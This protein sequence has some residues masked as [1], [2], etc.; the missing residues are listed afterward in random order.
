MLFFL[1]AYGIGWLLWLP[2]L[3][4]RKGLGLISVDLDFT[5]AIPG[6]FSPL[7][8]AL[9]V[10][11]IIMGNF[12]FGSLLGSR[13]RLLAAFGFGFLTVILSY[14]LFPA[15][16]IA[17]G[18][19][20]S[21]NTG[22]LFSWPSYGFSLLSLLGG[23]IGEEPGWRGF[24]LP[25]LQKRFGP[26]LASCILAILWAGWHLPAFLLN[27]WAGQP[28][29]SYIF[30]LA[31]FSII[32]T[33]AANISG[34]SIIVAVL[35]HVLLNSSSGLMWQVVGTVPRRTDNPLALV[36]LVV[37][38]SLLLPT[39]LVV[40]TKGNLFKKYYPSQSARTKNAR[41]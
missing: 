8:A 30:W 35:L 18:P 5:W 26:A 20:N 34:F 39:L 9:I 31:A 40:V 41:I 28:F 10:Q 1:L 27:G 7:L 37:G 15:L 14:V 21:L 19:L 29:W 4:S 38:P 11:W 25:R 6:S 17:S 16:A 12:K 2:L 36:C 23:P 33:C 22:L 32:A 13:W 3:C 24:A